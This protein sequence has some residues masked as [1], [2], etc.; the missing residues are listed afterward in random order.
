ME[1]RMLRRLKNKQKRHVFQIMTNTDIILSKGANP[2]FEPGISRI[3]D[4]SLLH[5]NT[6][7][8]NILAHRGK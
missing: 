2:R 8:S 3:Y 7:D 1:E 4:T 5:K 6:N